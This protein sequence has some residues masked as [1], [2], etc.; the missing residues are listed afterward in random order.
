MIRAVSNPPR[1]EQQGISNP[2]TVKADDGAHK[3]IWRHIS[4]WVT[5]LGIAGGVLTAFLTFVGITFDLFPALKPEEPPTELAVAVDDVELEERVTTESGAHRLI[6]S[7]GITFT[8]YR[9]TGSTSN[10]RPSI[11]RRS[12]VSGSRRRCH[13]E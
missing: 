13:F 2:E 5:A 9:E 11:R 8:G 10:G 7:Y 1:I 3:G 12:R 6:V 4:G